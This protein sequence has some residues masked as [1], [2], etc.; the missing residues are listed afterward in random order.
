[1]ISTGTC[2]PCLHPLRVLG[3]E[4]YE[5]H[6]ASFCVYPENNPLIVSTGFSLWGPMARRGG[7]TNR[8]DITLSRA[9]LYQKWKQPDMSDIRPQEP[10]SPGGGCTAVVTC[11]LQGLGHVCPVYFYC[12][13]RV[14]LRYWGCIISRAR[15]RARTSN[16][17][18]ELG[19]ETGLDVGLDNFSLSRHFHVLQIPWG[20]G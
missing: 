13:L 5:D 1:M 3:T 19:L 11:S 6:W 4:F 7:F 17:D 20:L 2:Q 10:T 16:Q 18:F 9:W 8:G 15:T 12:Q 14:L